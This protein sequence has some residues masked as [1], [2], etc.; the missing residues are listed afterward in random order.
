M[1]AT[2]SRP[3]SPASFKYRP[4]WAAIGTAVK[5]ALGEGVSVA[6]TSRRAPPCST[7]GAAAGPSYD[8]LLLARLH[9]HS[10][11][12]STARRR[13][14]RSGLL[15]NA[16]PGGLSVRHGASSPASSAR[17]GVGAALRRLREGRDRAG[18][19]DV[20]LGHRHRC[21]GPARSRRAVLR[22][23]PRM[24]SGSAVRAGL[25]GGVGGTITMSSYGY[26]LYAK[27][28]GAKWLSMMRLDNLV[29]H[30]H[31]PVRHRDAGGRCDDHVQR[32]SPRATAGCSCSAT[33]S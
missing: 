12:L 4:L 7:A 24:P 14:R 22:P 19:G 8:D 1:L 32:R 9:R 3:S 33:G 5:L 25:I 15:L 29:G 30:V 16:L 28:W 13:C 27:G 23:G 31:R 20:H 18:R 10:R 26:W 2:S 17:A 21:A 11:L 6:G